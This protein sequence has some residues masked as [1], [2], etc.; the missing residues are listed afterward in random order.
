MSFDIVELSNITDCKWIFR[1]KTLN[2]S[3]NMQITWESA[4]K[5]LVAVEKSQSQQANKY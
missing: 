3:G 4:K 2:I 5:A 1:Q